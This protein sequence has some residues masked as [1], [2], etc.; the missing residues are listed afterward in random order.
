MLNLGNPQALKWAI[1]YFDRFISDQG[2][3]VFRIDGDPPLPVWRSQDTEDRQGITE[4]RHIEGLLKFWDELQ[5]RH[6]NLMHDICGG[7]G[8]RNELEAL[9]RAVPLWRSDYA[10]ET[11]GMQNMTYGMSLW[12]PFFGTGVNALDAYTFRSQM[13][14][15]ISCVWD[16]RRQDLDYDFMRR[17]TNQW[18]KVAD[19]Y[20]GDFYP[21]TAY[22]VENDGW[23][24]WQVDRPETGT[25]MIQA[26]RRPKSDVVTMRFLLQGLD[27]KVR[28]AVTNLDQTDTMEITGQE[29]MEKGLLISLEERPDS[30]LIVYH[31]LQ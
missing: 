12:I 21:L 7:G 10:Y 13:A 3:D 17:M 23:M 4:I 2:V 29:L 25:G 30:A 9:R 16:L 28:Y 24:A 20:Y 1:D 5:Q 27:S 6:P 22:R 8:G 31:P 11:T 18:R 19:N 26:F 14:P 15:A